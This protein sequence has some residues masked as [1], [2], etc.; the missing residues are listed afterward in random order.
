MAEDSALGC[1]WV[2]GGES[3]CSLRSPP[4]P[5]WCLWAC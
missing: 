4:L 3:W 5:L 2:A 1:G